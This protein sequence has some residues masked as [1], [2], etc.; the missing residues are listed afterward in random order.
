MKWSVTELKADNGATGAAPEDGP[1]VFTA[2]QEQLGLRLQP[3]KGMFNVWT[4]DA[5]KRPAAN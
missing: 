5:V 4:L 1:T 3:E 2:L